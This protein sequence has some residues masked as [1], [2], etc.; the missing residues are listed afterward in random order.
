MREKLLAQESGD[1][2]PAEWLQSCVNIQ[3]AERQPRWCL[4]EC[5][6]FSNLTLHSLCLTVLWILR[7]PQVTPSADNLEPAWLSPGSP[8]AILLLEGRKRG[9]EGEPPKLMIAV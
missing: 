9:L 3:A 1:T 6:L 5:R 2:Q 7:T 4:L 8:S